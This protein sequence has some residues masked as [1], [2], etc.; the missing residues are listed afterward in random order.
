MAV[1][2]TPAGQRTQEIAMT[3]PGTRVRNSD[4]TYTT[5]REPLNPPTAWAKL[6]IADARSL[7]RVAATSSTTIGVASHVATIPYHPEVTMKTHVAW[8]DRFGGSHNANVL[9]YSNP[10]GKGIETVMVIAEIK[11]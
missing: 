7:E 10:D 6:E 11:P 9:G 5:P 1:K 2:R 3:N 4:G 8:I